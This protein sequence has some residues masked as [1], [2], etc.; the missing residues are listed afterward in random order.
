MSANWDVRKLWWELTKLV[1]TGRARYDVYANVEGFHGDL[2]E[3]LT[4]D[5]LVFNNLEWVGGEDRF[6]LLNIE[7][8]G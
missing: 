5:E 6:V 8:E 2:A 4:R 3:Q 7:R 1:L